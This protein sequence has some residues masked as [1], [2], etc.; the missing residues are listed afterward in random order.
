[1]SIVIKNL[2]TDAEIREKAV[3][4]WKAWREAYGGIVERRYLDEHT[5]ERCEEM[6]LR[7]KENTIIAKKDGRVV[8]FIQYE[9]NR[10]GDL[11]NTGEIS[12]LYVLAED[13]G[14]G[15]GGQLM[16]E[17]L[18]RLKE[19]PRIAIW[20][21]RENERAIGFYKRYGF[22]FDGHQ[23]MTQ[24]GAAAVRMILERQIPACPDERRLPPV[25]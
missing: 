9:E 13:H 3:V 15:I 1:M 5:L 11:Q 19:Y 25:L 10:D 12:A 8:G 4:H 17:A 23:G 22:R 6:A 21:L 16:R 2:E 7:A 20:V 24:I 14:R 18:L